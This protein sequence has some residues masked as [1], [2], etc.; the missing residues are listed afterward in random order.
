MN[1]GKLINTEIEMKGSCLGNTDQHSDPLDKWYIRDTN[2]IARGQFAVVYHCTHRITG[3]EFAAKFS[4]RVRLGIDSTKDILH[5]V[6]VCAMLKPNV[7]TV[8]LCDVFS[9]EEEMV[10][11][12]E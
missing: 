7:R 11:V 4:S 2:P 10:L 6:A 8:Q 5:E 12:M 1:T 9:N 3:Q